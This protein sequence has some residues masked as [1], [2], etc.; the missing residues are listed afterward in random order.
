V[1]NP[2]LTTPLSVEI[3]WTK[4]E[5]K[6]NFGVHGTNM[7]IIKLAKSQPD[8]D[9]STVDVKTTSPNSNLSCG[10]A[11]CTFY[12]PTN[13]V[14]LEATNA[15]GSTFVGWSD[16]CATTTGSLNRTKS[17]SL[18]TNGNQICTAHFESF[19]C[20]NVT[21]IP[22]EECQ[23][24]VSIFN[25][26]SGKFWTNLI[27][28]RNT[29]T[30]CSWYG[31]N[32]TNGKVSAINLSN[33][34]LNGS[35]PSDL[36]VLSGLQSFDVSGNSHL[37][38]T[39]PSS[40]TNI[41]TLTD[42]K[43]SST[44]LCENLNVDYGVAWGD[45]AEITDL[46][47]CPQIPPVATFN[48]LPPKGS[49]TV[50]LDATSVSNLLNNPT[51]IYN[52][53]TSC[54]IT[55]TPEQ[56]L[57]R[58]ATGMKTAITFSQAVICDVTL[59]VTD[60]SGVVINTSTINMPITQKRVKVPVVSPII[61]K[62][63]DGLNG[64]F[65][66]VS[67]S[68][69]NLTVDLDATVSYDPDGEIVDYNWITSCGPSA[70][71]ISPSITFSQAATCNI[72]LTVTDD[73]GATN[74]FTQTIT[75]P[76]VTLTTVKTGNGSGQIVATIIEKDSSGKVTTTPSSLVPQNCFPDVCL[77]QVNSFRP[78]ETVRLSAKGYPGYK[79]NGWGGAC[80]DTTDPNVL[81]TEPIITMVFGESSK[82][83]TAE[84]EE[85][86]TVL[87][88]PPYYSV[89]VEL[90]DIKTSKMNLSAGQVV[91]RRLTINY[92]D[93]YTKNKAYYEHTPGESG[94]RVRLK[95]I[96][97]HPDK[98]NSGSNTYWEFVRWECYKKNDSSTK[99]L[100]LRSTM[101][102]KPQM[103]F[104]VPEFD[105]I[106]RAYFNSEQDIAGQELKDKTYKGGTI[107][108]GETP[109]ER[110][111]MDKGNNAARLREALY[112]AQPAI[113]AIQAIVDLS[114]PET[115]EETW[116]K[117]TADDP[118]SLVD[119][120]FFRPASA[121][122]EKEEGKE[123]TKS[124]RIRPKDAEV[125]G[126]VST[127]T[128]EGYYIEIRVMLMNK[129]GVEEEVPILKTYEDKSQSSVRRGL[130]GGRSITVGSIQI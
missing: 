47:E 64:V 70:K 112:W 58:K 100:L 99:V 126:F 62:T 3:S 40:L 25:N 33:N 42:L 24:L 98:I 109:S 69:G 127:G 17:Y 15:V 4:Q 5:E 31:I 43:V 49:L 16:N 81:V 53:D 37:G 18:T 96:P 65:Q 55:A 97:N 67:S 118:N 87:T 38:S 78:G 9:E 51:A 10:V 125:V 110:Y 45:K 108:T 90:W 52:W 41:S 11:A 35:L 75:V 68:K 122:K 88:S 12:L 121:G 115:I 66:I 102:K 6:V 129:D 2:P 61:V 20:D 91:D 116:P 89:E 103:A 113:L 56:T 28:W 23:A 60:A 82:T 77:T 73:A 50:E 117:A 48:I 21:E 71:G 111:P 95:A 13:T 101:Q 84:F 120:E 80:G 86:P 57:E 39:L 22:K 130:R 119:K 26:T 105:T 19:T 93:G 34:N 1:R 114:T 44:S 74:S 104:E 27:D 29:L 83:C 63:D 54:S 85:D 7:L 123:Y 76:M 128:V 72:I 59:T 46:E 79:F 14:T 92:G 30:P 36:S 107:D 124:I 8:N 94:D 106:C 32:C